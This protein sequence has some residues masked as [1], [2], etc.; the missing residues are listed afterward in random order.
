MPAA[1]ASRQSTSFWRFTPP[2]AY[3]GRRT[4]AVASR[5]ASSPSG[6][7]DLVGSSKPVRTQRSRA[8]MAT[9][10]R[11]LVSGLDSRHGRYRL[12]LE[13]GNR[14]GV[15]VGNAA[16]T[17]GAN[18]ANAIS[19]NNAWTEYVQKTEEAA[20]RADDVVPDDGPWTDV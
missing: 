20:V 15:V 16:R 7:T 6:L 19:L 3:T 1:P 5:S 18:P 11:S 12:Q 10:R 2:S 17:E 14:P 8:G 9:E 13:R 4:A